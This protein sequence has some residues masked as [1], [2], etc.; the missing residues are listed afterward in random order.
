MPEP[1]P[2]FRHYIDPVEDTTFLRDEDAVCDACGRA[3]GWIAQCMFFSDSVDDLT[4]CPWCI[5]DGTAT[6]RFGG[7]FNTVDP[8]IPPE[9]AAIVALRTPALN[10]CDEWDWPGHCDYP[11]VYVDEDIDR[12]KRLPDAVES[13]S[14]FSRRVHGYDDEACDELLENEWLDVYLFRCCICGT[15]I[16]LWDAE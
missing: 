15:H 13:I 2:A 3:R 16:A 1:L 12:I 14:E 7:F 9:R 4:I 5:A 8:A 6:R 10:T 11:A